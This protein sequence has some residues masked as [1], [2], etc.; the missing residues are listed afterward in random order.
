METPGINKEPLTLILEKNWFKSN[1]WKEQIWLV[2]VYSILKD[3]KC[4]FKQ[5]KELFA[6]LCEYPQYFT[7]HEP[8]QQGTNFVYT[9]DIHLDL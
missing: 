5:Q 4:P 6:I 2:E 8:V 3:N 7:I 1:S 9:I